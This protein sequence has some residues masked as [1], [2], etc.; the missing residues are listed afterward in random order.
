VIKGGTMESVMIHFKHS[1]EYDTSWTPY[2]S[3][4]SGKRD[5]SEIAAH[6]EGFLGSTGTQPVTGIN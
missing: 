1:N 6:R 4:I 3:G 5:F 2:H